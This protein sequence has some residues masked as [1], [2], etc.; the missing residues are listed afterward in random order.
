MGKFADAVKAFSEKTKTNVDAT[1]KESILGIAIE[2]VDRSPVGDPALWAS[3]PPKTYVPGTFKAN[4]QGGIGE[5]N[6]TIT[7]ETDPSGEISIVSISAMLEGVDPKGIFYITN[8]LPYAIPLEYGHSSQAPQG[9][10]GLT[11]IEWQNIV[12][13]AKLAVIR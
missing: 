6:Y 7:D 2:L 13:K 12:S 9:I 8:S 4:W 10:V 11:A 5:I 1:I 3:K